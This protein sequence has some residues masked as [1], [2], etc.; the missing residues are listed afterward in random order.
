MGVSPMKKTVLEEMEKLG[1]KLG[2]LRFNDLWLN[3]PVIPEEESLPEVVERPVITVSRVDRKWEIPSVIHHEDIITIEESRV[4]RPPFIPAL[5]V[6]IRVGVFDKKSQAIKAQRKI[7][8]KL[9]LKAEII[10]QWD[11]YTVLIRGFH[12]R[13]E[14]YRYYPELAAIGY[15]GISIIEE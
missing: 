5:S 13:E 4:I 1:P 12:T 15:P 8:S 7:A 14:T 10:Q 6:S 9:N 11:Q 3:L 2:K